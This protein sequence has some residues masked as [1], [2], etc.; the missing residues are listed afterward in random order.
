MD[1]IKLITTSFI[2]LFLSV[3]L[4]ESRGTHEKEKIIAKRGVV[5]NMLTA[6]DGPACSYIIQFAYAMAKRKL[7]KLTEY[8]L[9][10][11][12]YGDEVDRAE[13]GYDF[14]L[15]ERENPS[16]FEIDLKTVLKEDFDDSDGV[17]FKSFQNIIKRR[18]SGVDDRVP[19]GDQEHPMEQQDDGGVFTF[20][21]TSSRGLSCKLIVE[22][23]K[24]YAKSSFQDLLKYVTSNLTNIVG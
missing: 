16:K 21:V 14:V 1:Y 17:Q 12:P 23:I 15:N 10:N 6:G 4:S 18:F 24:Y 19:G 3:T 20:L 22:Y 5:E 2:L 11:I 13:G 7:A 9:Q 8:M